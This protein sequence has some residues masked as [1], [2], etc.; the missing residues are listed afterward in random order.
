MKYLALLVILIGL[1]GCAGMQ[2]DRSGVELKYY[3]PDSPEEM[4]ILFKSYWTF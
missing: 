3:T 1:S 2:Y 4:S